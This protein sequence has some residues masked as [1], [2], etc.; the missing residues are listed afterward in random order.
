[1][2]VEPRLVKSLVGF[3]NF[4]ERLVSSPPK[5]PLREPFPLIALQLYTE[6]RG[7]NVNAYYSS[8]TMSYI[9]GSYAEELLAKQQLAAR[10]SVQSLELLVLSLEDHRFAIPIYDNGVRSC[11]LVYSQS[12]RIVLIEY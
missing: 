2:E 8:R 5:S 4:C 9:N 6:R 11:L 3:C 7:K 1:M 10:S 12:G